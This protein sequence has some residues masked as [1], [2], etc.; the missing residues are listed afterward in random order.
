MLENLIGI[1]TILA[2]Y[3]VGS[4]G[5]AKSKQN[6][7][8]FSKTMTS[9]LETQLE[10]ARIML[11]AE[12]RSDSSSDDETS[13]DASSTTEQ[14]ENRFGRLH[15]YISCLA[16]LPPLLEKYSCNP[17]RGSA[18][19]PI[20]AGNVFRLFHEAQPFAMRV[21]DRSVLSRESFLVYDIC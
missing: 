21:R 19:Q 6:E 5:T 18:T 14:Q 4:E 1:G 10:K 17:Q 2:P 16:D 7:G 12:E 11:A 13:D 15:C 9:E 8:E 3:F 20:P